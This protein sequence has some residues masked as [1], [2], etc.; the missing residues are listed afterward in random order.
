MSKIE[1][2]KTTW[3]EIDLPEIEHYIK[4]SNR[5]FPCCPM[6]KLKELKKSLERW[7]KDNGVSFDDELYKYFRAQVGTV[8]SSYEI[9]LREHKRVARLKKVMDTVLKLTDDNILKKFIIDDVL[10]RCGL[11]LL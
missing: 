11:N 8:I 3:R 6:P 2:Q 7:A 10:A 4:N 5:V 1:L 9:I